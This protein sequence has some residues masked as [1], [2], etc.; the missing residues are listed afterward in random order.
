[1]IISTGMRTDIP[2]F[3]S[4]WFMNRLREGFVCVRNPYRQE[5]VTKYSLSPKVV[6]CITFCTKN[7]Q[8]ML[9]HIAE[10]KDYGQFWFVTITPY[11][12]DIEPNVPPVSEVVGSFKKLSAAVGSNAVSW[13]Y[14]PIFLGRGYDTNKHVREFEKIAKE[15]KG[16]TNSCVISFLDKY[17]KVERNAP[18]IYPPDIE[19]QKALCGALV[20]IGNEN[21]IKIKSCC[22]NAC[23]KECGA[24]AAGC[25]T[26]ATIENAIGKSLRVPKRKNQRGS[27]DCLL[28]SDIGAYDSCGHLCKYC[29]ANANK[30]FVLKNM[31]LH[32]PDSPFLIGNYRAG[33]VVTEAKQTRYIDGQISM[34]GSEI[35]KNSTD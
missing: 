27:C 23:L 3:Y 21:G 25:Q 10:L 2:A 30:E 11:G 16:F 8:P 7:P 26:K 14:D 35:W 15:L 28:G 17:K 18:D 20:K 34:F 12:K 6:D 1:M 29:Y 19:A 4:K 24:D 5:Q 22:E 33:D 9:P 13:R 31:K 32:D